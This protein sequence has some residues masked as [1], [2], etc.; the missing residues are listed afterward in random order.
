MGLELDAFTTSIERCRSLVAAS[1]YLRTQAPGLA[2]VAD[3]MLRA[4]LAQAVSAQDRYIHERVRTEMVRAARNERDRTPSLHR[5]SVP[6]ANALAG[7][8]HNLDFD[9]WL[10][11]AIVEQHALLSFQRADKVA[12]AMRLV[13]EIEGGLWPGVAAHM[14]ENDVGGVKTRLNLIVDR[15]NQIVHQDDSDLAGARLPI[16]TALVTAALDF[17]ESVVEAID[18][19]TE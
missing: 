14:G 13:C 19:L 17:V 16:D 8:E 2:E 9:G 12:D 7:I 1:D 11:P 10:N 3:D 5:F 15:R 6:L 18:G 4:A